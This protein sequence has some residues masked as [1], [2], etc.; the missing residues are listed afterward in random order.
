MKLIGSVQ[1]I[2]C[3]KGFSMESEV[4]Q[5][6]KEIRGI[7]FFMVVIFGVFVF[8]LALGIIQIIIKRYKQNLSNRWENIAGNLFNKAKYSELIVHCNTRLSGFPNDVNAVWWL[9]KSY[10]ELGD[11]E[12]AKLLFIKVGELE[13]SWKPAYVDPY[14][15]DGELLR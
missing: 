9:A 5:T 1:V 8:F 11:Y 6:L 7:L 12:D 10:K 4:L 3:Q 15:K 13:P 2:H 14:F